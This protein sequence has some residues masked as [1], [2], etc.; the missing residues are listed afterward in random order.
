M[1]EAERK[2]WR[3]ARALYRLGLVTL[4]SLVAFYC[5]PNVILFHK[6]T[7]LA[8]SDFADSVRTKGNPILSAME[9]YR[10]DQGQHPQDLAEL[11]PRY[12]PTK[13]EAGTHF[14]GYT[15]TIWDWERQHHWIELDLTRPQDG[16]NVHGGFAH[17][18][19]PVAPV[20]FQPVRSPY[21]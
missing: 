2:R 19:I 21:P 12:L 1:D 8:P 13:V 7:R 5:G 18:R 9:R 10:A 3:R 14:D 17:G 11:T 16:W 4:F 20:P 6:L 15:L